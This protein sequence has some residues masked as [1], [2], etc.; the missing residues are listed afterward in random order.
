MI[1]STNLSGLIFFFIGWYHADGMQKVTGG[2]Q[3]EISN[4]PLPWFCRIG[5]VNQT[6]AWQNQYIHF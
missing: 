2:I 3:G 5:K 1:P 6:G 4:N